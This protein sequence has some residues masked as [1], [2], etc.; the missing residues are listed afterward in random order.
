MDPPLGRLD[1]RWTILLL[2]LFQG[3]FIYVNY[4]LE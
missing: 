2:H 4:L 1:A 3:F